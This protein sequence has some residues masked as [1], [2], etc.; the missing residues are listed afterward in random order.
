MFRRLALPAVA[1]ALLALPPVAPAADGDGLKRLP[2]AV[3]TALEK[4]DVVEL[5]AINPER[6]QKPEGDAVGGYAVTKKVEL[7]AKSDDREGLTVAL[8]KTLSAAGPPA[9]CFIPRHA[10]R[11]THDKK[12]YALLICYQC[13]SLR[14]FTD[15]KDGGEI[16]IGKT[17]QK[18]LNT[19]LGLNAKVPVK[20]VKPVE[21][22][23]KA[24]EG[25][26]KLPEAVRTAL[27][28]AA[29]VE[30]MAINPEG[31]AGKNVDAIDGYAVGTKI[32]LLSASDELAAAL[33]AFD[34]SLSEGDS[35]AKCFNPRHAFRATFEKKV[36]EILICFECHQVHLFEDGKRVGGL[37]ISKSAQPTL[38]KLL[39]AP[40]APKVTKS[41][42]GMKKL[43]AAFRTALDQAPVVHLLQVSPNKAEGKVDDAVDNYPVRKVAKLTTDDRTISLILLDEALAEG[44]VI[45]KEFTARHVV[46]AVHDGKK[47][48]ILIGYEGTQAQLFLDGKPVGDPLPI[49]T[50]TKE[51][52][53][54]I[55]RNL[56]D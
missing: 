2:E 3:R 55:L 56:L 46:R 51:S 40:P 49:S 31:G 17:G 5:L 54:R 6:G 53:N 7:K 32:A 25:L 27:A 1:A 15:G 37:P 18:T 52:F 11:A 10:V 19:L 33:K 22:V 42:D 14:V 45:G 38:D 34:T 24:G 20:P 21:P 26:K 4:A 39:A 50:G 13:N 30:L 8:D 44:S 43:P 12:T 23:T 36:Y 16:P 35:L 47:Y 29:A 41:G 9:D 28:K 48:E